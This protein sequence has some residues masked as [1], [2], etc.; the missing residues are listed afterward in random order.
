VLFKTPVQYNRKSATYCRSGFDPPDIIYY[1]IHVSITKPVVSALK[2]YCTYGF[3]EVPTEFLIFKP[4]LG[5]GGRFVSE[6][7]TRRFQ[8][9]NGR[10][11]AV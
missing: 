9:Q 2:N 1:F 8:K 5:P 3:L 7:A 11:V 4:L 6:T 10:Y